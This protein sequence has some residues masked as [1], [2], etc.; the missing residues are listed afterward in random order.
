M[1]DHVL[2]FRDMGEMEPR[3]AEGVAL[4]RRAGSR[5]PDS[6]WAL[7]QLIFLLEATEQWPWDPGAKQGF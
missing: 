2:E 3:G 7:S 4:V 6:R 1:T 5:P